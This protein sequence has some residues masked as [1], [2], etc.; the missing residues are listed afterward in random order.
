[1]AIVIDVFK[2]ED[3]R[4]H[5]AL[6][7]TSIE[8]NF[9]KSSIVIE[10][11]IGNYISY[12][13]TLTDISTKLDGNHSKA[14]C[15]WGSE[16]NAMNDHYD[17]LY[18]GRFRAVTKQRCQENLIFVN[19]IIIPTQEDGDEKSLYSE[20]DI[21]KKWRNF[22]PEDIN[23]AN[24]QKQSTQFDVR[25]RHCGT[26]IKNV[27]ENSNLSTERAEWEE[28]DSPKHKRAIITRS[29]INTIELAKSKQGDEKSNPLN[30]YYLKDDLLRFYED[31]RR[32]KNFWESDPSEYKSLLNSC[33]Q[34]TDKSGFVLKTTFST[35]L[36]TDIDT[37]L[38]KLNHENTDKDGKRITNPVVNQAINSLELYKWHREKQKSEYTGFFGI[39]GDSKKVKLDT[40]NKYQRLLKGHSRDSVKVNEDERLA[41]L[42]DK[43]YKYYVS[44]Y[45][46]TIRK[47]VN[48]DRPA[49]GQYENFRGLLS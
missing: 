30:K 47:I 43:L 31:Y 28:K 26:I 48:L 17:P 14:G 8:P 15:N 10:D 35:S 21:A 19:R 39:F 33:Y 37:Y 45:E 9:E 27:L 13:S 41:L 3:D 20:K 4:I 49:L 7:L 32:W 16:P 23:K 44:P 12:F 24:K 40:V 22:R 11:E 25:Y 46:T 29:L 6:G 18:H 5:L 36:Q 1:M 38:E 42:S 2:F 34:K